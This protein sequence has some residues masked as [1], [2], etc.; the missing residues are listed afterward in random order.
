MTTP[1]PPISI[2]EQQERLNITRRVRIRESI[3]S[4][5]LWGCTLICAAWTI[6]SPAIIPAILIVGFLSGT[7]CSRN[8]VYLLKEEEHRI[9]RLILRRK[10][11]LWA[12]E[13]N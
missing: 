13:T 2:R 11:E 6:S 3:V 10:Q 9:Q 8:R 1:P 7:V 4:W 5:F 12:H